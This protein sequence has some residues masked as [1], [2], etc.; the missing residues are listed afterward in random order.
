[1]SLVL[2]IPGKSQMGAGRTIGFGLSAAI[3]LIACT[4][5]PER[6]LSWWQS[7]SLGASTPAGPN[8]AACPLGYGDADGSKPTCDELFEQVIAPAVHVDVSVWP[9]SVFYCPESWFAGQGRHGTAVLLVPCARGGQICGCRSTAR[10]RG[11]RQVRPC[12]ASIG[13]P[14]QVR[15]CLL[16]LDQPSRYVSVAL[17]RRCHQPRPSLL[18]RCQIGACAGRRL[19]RAL[20][21]YKSGISI[22]EEY[23]KRL[24]ALN[25]QNPSDASPAQARSLAVGS[26]VWT[27]RVHL[28][29]FVSAVFAG[30]R[31]TTLPAAA[32]RP[33]GKGTSAAPRMPP[34]AL[35]RT[36]IFPTRPSVAS[37]G[38]MRR[39][40]S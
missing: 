6:I 38:A 16:A 31:C 15:P 11:V 32:P 10:C 14:Q 28:V 13:G 20:E 3:M 18:V 29:L 35:A 21:Q 7:R 17:V 12:A 8:E 25:L 33:H 27:A 4:D 36:Q 1:M 23:G 26:S 5:A 40:E 39:S 19:C 30:Q 2:E 34:R 24:S 22:L 37:L 9:N